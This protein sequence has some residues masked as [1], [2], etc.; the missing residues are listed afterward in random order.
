MVMHLRL[1]KAEPRPAYAI[2]KDFE[3]Y[4]DE[5]F[6]TAKKSDTSRKR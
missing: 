5:C 2:V 1:V 3:R 6:V 4:R